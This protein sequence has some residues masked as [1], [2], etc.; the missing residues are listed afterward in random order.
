MATLILLC[1]WVPVLS[2][3]FFWSLTG[4]SF[5][6]AKQNW[7][8]GLQFTCPPSFVQ[9]QLNSCFAWHKLCIYGRYLEDKG[10]VYFAL[11]LLFWAFWSAVVFQKETPAMFSSKNT[12]SSVLYVSACGV[13]GR[14]HDAALLQRPLSLMHFNIIREERKCFSELTCWTLKNKQA[15]FL[16]LHNVSKSRLHPSPKSTLPKPK[17]SWEEWAPSPP[18]TRR[19]KMS[20]KKSFLT[21]TPCAF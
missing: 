19:L 18:N 1:V 14:K 3:P 11:Y 20:N 5:L 9:D 21:L 7:F 6:F 13:A 8:Q 16:K 12:F 17:R 10:C 15:H 2:S 4:D